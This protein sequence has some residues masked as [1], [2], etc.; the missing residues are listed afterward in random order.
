MEGGVHMKVDGDGGVRGVHMKISKCHVL[1][2]KIK[3]RSK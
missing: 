1:N 2:G 3:D